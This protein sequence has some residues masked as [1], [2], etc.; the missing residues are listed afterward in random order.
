MRVI[1]CLPDCRYSCRK[2]LCNSETRFYVWRAH[3]V[4]KAHSPTPSVYRQRRS[5]RRKAFFGPCTRSRDRHG[6]EW[7]H[8]S[9]A[10]TDFCRLMQLSRAPTSIVPTFAY[11]QRA[12]GIPHSRAGYQQ[13]KKTQAVGDFRVSF[14]RGVGEGKHVTCDKQQVSSSFPIRSQ[15]VKSMGH[16]GDMR[17]STTRFRDMTEERLNNELHIAL[18]S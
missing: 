13:H 12:V 18:T 14:A 17:V 8:R 4:G 10:R 16:V 1:A 15:R 9:L 5:P 11:S 2:F 6:A 3:D 7:S